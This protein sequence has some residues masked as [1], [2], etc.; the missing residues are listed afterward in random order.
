LWIQTTYQIEPRRYKPPKQIYN[1]Q[2][3][4]TNN[5]E[6]SNKENP[7]PDGFNAKFYQ[8][9]KELIPIL[10]NTPQTILQDRKGRHT[11]KFILWSQYYPDTKKQKK[12]WPKEENHRA[13]SLLS[14]VKCLS[15]IPANWIQLNIK[16]IIYLDQIGFIPGM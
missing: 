9:F 12:T 15:K 3:D 8:A 5:K 16:K 11:T 14:L 4:W 13:V 1:K 6:T 7:V 10:L 2:W